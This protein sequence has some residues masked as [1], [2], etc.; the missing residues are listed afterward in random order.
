MR[1]SLEQGEALV[2]R[3]NETCR[4]PAR[5]QLV[6]AMNECPCGRG[7]G[8]DGCTCG[9]LEISRY[10]RRVS[11]ALLDRIDIFVA[12]ERTCLRELV[13]ADAGEPT[14]EVRK[15][16]IAARQLQRQRNRH[17]AGE[18]TGL[19]TTLPARRLDVA[20]GLGPSL[21]SK[22]RGFADDLRLS[23]RAWHRMLRVARTIA[24]LDGAAGVQEQHALEALRYRP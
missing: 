5:F 14:D 12:V 13:H 24:D 21:L 17:F 3:A 4:F 11:G 23:T 6:A 22:V 20:C 18:P 8:D 19:N 1:Q 7:P 9:D 15:R 2:V 16:V 10:R